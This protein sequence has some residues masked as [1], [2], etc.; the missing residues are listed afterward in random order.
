V[1]T[2]LYIS[3]YALGNLRFGGYS[4][5]FLSWYPIHICFKI[6]TKKT[7]IHSVGYKKTRLFINLKNMKTLYA[8]IIHVKCSGIKL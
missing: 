4:I 2:A 1:F 7:K 3:F 6:L 5:H 8:G